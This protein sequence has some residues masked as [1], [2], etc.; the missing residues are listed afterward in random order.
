MLAFGRIFAIIAAQMKYFSVHQLSRSVIFYFLTC[1]R[2][3]VI[4]IFSFV[5]MA[6]L[7]AKLYA[8][9]DSAEVTYKIA[10][11]SPLYLDSAFANGNYQLGKLSIPRHFMQGLD[12]YN[13]V[14]IAVDTLQKKG[15]KIE[16]FVYD[17]K[18][19]SFNDT[20]HTA[21]ASQHFSL[22][23]AY[24]N[25]A[26][27][28]RLVSQLSAASGVPLI[29]ATYPND[30]GLSN[31]PHFVMINPTIKTHIEN[32]YRFIQRNYPIAKV[33]YVSR[34]G[35]MEDRI[36]NFFAEAA[37]K[38]AVLKYKSVE[39]P[40]DFTEQMLMPYLDSSKQNLIICGSINEAFGEN[41]L[42][43]IE[44]SVAYRIVAVGMPTWDGMKQVSTSIN[45]NIDIVYSTPF[46]YTKANKSVA[47]LANN[48]KAKFFGR[49]SDMVYKGYE[50]MYHF[51]MLL[52]KHKGQLT[53]NLT[54]AEFKFCNE[55]LLAPVINAENADQVEYLENKKLYFITM[56]QGTVKAV[57]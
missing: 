35:T 27:E 46:N 22:I 6:S 7:P 31:N 4:I 20:M 50:S 21:M 28:Q 25:N 32:I 19:R 55:Y 5:F 11:L 53:E 57:N 24:F 15:A 34:K 13:G 8:Q 40:D 48:Y 52:L 29:S 51:A 43:V 14:M 1:F 18:M 16:V 30:A 47:T 44:Q 49:P 12:F 3:R 33:I 41:L 45:K 23:I 9:T 36:K 42:N 10:V 2:K 38:T 56:A 54:D 39:L 37:K 26:A 17:T